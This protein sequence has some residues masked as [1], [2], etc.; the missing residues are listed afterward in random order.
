[1]SVGKTV[2]YEKVNV[3]G[4]PWPVGANRKKLPFC[5]WGKQDKHIQT[6]Q[7]ASSEGFGA[8]KWPAPECTSL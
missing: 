2:E 5:P 6:I 7:H 1:M 3:S 8:E 4:N